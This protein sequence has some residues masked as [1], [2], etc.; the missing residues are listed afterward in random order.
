M[1]ISVNSGDTLFSISRMYGIP[2][3]KIAADNGILNDSLV[4][5]QSLIIDNPD[6]S[7]FTSND[8]SASIISEKYSITLRNLFR[9]NYFLKGRENV[10][11]NSLV[12]L[13]YM[14][15]PSISKITG[16]YA[17]DFI[18]AERL[19]SVI[20]YLTYI[21]P[22]TYGFTEKGELIS[23]DDGYIIERALIS[24]T[25]P[26]LHLSTL[27]GEGYF[28]SNLPERLFSSS[29]AVQK[30]IEGIIDMVESKG[31]EGVDTD[32]EYLPEGEKENYAD[33]LKKLSHSLHNKGKI[34]IVAVPPKASDEQRS[35]LV[36]GIDYKAIGSIADYILIM[37]YEYGY[38]FGPPLAIAPV[39]QVRSVLDYATNKINSEK[40]LLGIPNY[41]YDWT[42]PYV[43]GESDAP[44]ISTVEAIELAKRYGAEIQ[45]D[46][47]SEAP[48]FFYTDEAR[49]IHEVWFE[50]ARS[51]KAKVSLIEEYGL[52]GGF[53]WDL[54]R[55]NPQGFVTLN[56]LIDIV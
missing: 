52:A 13:S 1:I 17:Y 5:G 41:G 50:D 25:K 16:G 55:D 3:S 20:N 42:L 31:Y 27:T 12:V 38:K 4:V 2:I 7:I 30:L 19:S 15:T 43:R 56:S 34:L 54:M 37:A 47:A 35:V 28:D 46:V 51:Y 29:D 9:N 21:M 33:F 26:L 6:D 11:K 8:T 40:I 10:P 14:N 22:F 32:F 53:I 39:N 44:S 18:S 23:P 45:Y 48:Y 49:S 36:N 24:G